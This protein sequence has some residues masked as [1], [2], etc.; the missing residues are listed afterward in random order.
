MFGLLIEAQIFICGLK[1]KY[2]IISALF[3]LIMENNTL[4][5]NDILQ[6]GIMHQTHVPYNPHQNSVAERMNLTLLN[7]VHSMHFKKNL[8]LARNWCSRVMQLHV[9]PS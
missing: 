5:M 7:M 3:I 9:Q 2:N 8:K 4:L 1:M 6:D